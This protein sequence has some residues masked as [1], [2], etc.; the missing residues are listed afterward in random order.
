MSLENDVMLIFSFVIVWNY[1]LLITEQIY[2]T[3][4]F[5]FQDSEKP[6]RW[7]M[8][9]KESTQEQILK[10]SL[11]CNYNNL[12]IN[13]IFLFISLVTFTML[14]NL[15]H[16]NPWYDTNHFQVLLMLLSSSS[17]SVE[18][19]SQTGASSSAGSALLVSG[20]CDKL[21]GRRSP[22]SRF[23]AQ[24]YKCLQV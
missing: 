17:T 20:W 23:L 3:S 16:P 7:L 1:K 18:L 8:L 5:Y 11:L 9:A 4:E 21:T 10:N 13:S 15:Y 19:S 24:P 2:V 14:T 22:C 6:C 12:V